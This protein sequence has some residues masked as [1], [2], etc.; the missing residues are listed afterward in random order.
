LSVFPSP[1]DVLLFRNLAAQDVI[2]GANAVAQAV[3][4]IKSA[5]HLSKPEPTSGSGGGGGD[6]GAKEGSA[7]KSIF[8]SMFGKKK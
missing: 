6:G 5:P 2:G 7:R 4:L 1:D 8:G 3:K